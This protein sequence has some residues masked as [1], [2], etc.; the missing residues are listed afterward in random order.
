MNKTNLGIA[1]VI[2]ALAPQAYSTFLPSPREIRAASDDE[3]EISDIREGEIFGSTVVM[4]GSIAA[5]IFT[6]SVAPIVMGAIIV[7]VMVGIYEYTMSGSSAIGDMFKGA[8]NE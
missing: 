7:A 5:G 4:L 3:I 8:E 1:L 6:D 2:I